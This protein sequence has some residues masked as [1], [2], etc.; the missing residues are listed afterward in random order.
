[1]FFCWTLYKDSA[2]PRSKHSPPGLYQTNLLMLYEA[3]IAVIF[4]D[5]CT[6]PKRNVITM[7]E[8]S[9]ISIQSLGRF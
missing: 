7:Y 8:N 9:F 3:K 1:M 6:T 4:S 2:V 5:K